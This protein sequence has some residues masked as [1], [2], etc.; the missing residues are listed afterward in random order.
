VEPLRAQHPSNR[1]GAFLP[2]ANLFAVP[3]SPSATFAG[4]S[5]WL[6]DFVSS[7]ERVSMF[8]NRKRESSFRRAPRAVGRFPRNGRPSPPPWVAL[9]CL[10]VLISGF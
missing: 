4:S 6:R 5:N 2:P 1:L 3:L 10:N 9:E 7:L 8:S